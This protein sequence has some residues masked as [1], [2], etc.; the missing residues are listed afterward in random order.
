MAAASSSPSPFLHASLPQPSTPAPKLITTLSVVPR[1]LLLRLR[2]ADL[3][4]CPPLRR[5][6]VSALAAGAEL[7]EAD[8]E[9]AEADAGA[10]VLA[11][12][13]PPAKPKTG[14]AALPLKRDRVRTLGFARG[15]FGVRWSRKDV[16]FFGVL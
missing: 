5:L 2:A 7:A 1:P 14:K 10:D 13:A 16:K 12:A 6:S 8:A 4:P 3:I 15:L 11:D 9:L